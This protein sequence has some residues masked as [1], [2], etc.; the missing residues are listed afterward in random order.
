VE[1]LPLHTHG[2][3]PR[4]IPEAVIGFE[5]AGRERQRGVVPSN[6]VEKLRGTWI[7]PEIEIT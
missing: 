3:I 6:V 5:L 1:A 4:I 2:N 7:L